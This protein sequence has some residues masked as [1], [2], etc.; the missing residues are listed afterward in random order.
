MSQQAAPK[1][2]AVTQMLFAKAKQNSIK[3]TYDTAV[4]QRGHYQTPVCGCQHIFNVNIKVLFHISA[5]CFA[6]IMSDS[7]CHLRLE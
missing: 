3:K 6:S 5:A 2:A 4:T 1:E 7:V